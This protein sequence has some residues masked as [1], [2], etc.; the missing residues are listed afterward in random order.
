MSSFP[1]FDRLLPGFV[2]FKKRSVVSVVLV[3]ASA[4]LLT[5]S[6]SAQNTLV[7]PDFE[8]TGG[9]SSNY[10]LITTGP[11]TVNNYAITTN[12]SL[13]NP[14]WS[15]CTD[16]TS[17]S[18]KMMVVDGG[19]LPLN[20]V[21]EQVPGGGFSVVTGTVY[22]FS[23]WIA[24]INALNNTGSN[25][26][27]IKVLFDNVQLTPT[28][29]STTCPTTLCT[30]TKVEYT[31]TATNTYCQIWLYDTNTSTTANDFALDDFYFAPVPGPLSLTYSL[32]NPICPGASD[33]G[34]AV[35]GSGGTPP[36]TYSI[37]GGTYVTD[38]LFQGLGTSSNT[39]SIKDATGQVYT[40]T[41]TINL[42]G[43]ANPLVI[44]GNLSICSGS[45]T[46]TASGGNG[47]YSWTAS[48]TDATL[49]TP[50]AA[51]VTVSPIQ[52]TSYTV[53]SSAT[54]NANLIY[55]GNFSGGN[56]GFASDYTYASTNP[57]GAQKSYG[58][59]TNPNIFYSTFAACADHTSG[60]GNLLVADGSTVANSI[61]WRQK[62]PV[63]TNT[64]YTF[65]YWLESVTTSNPAQLETQING[66]PIT[67]TAATSTANALATTCTWSQVTY[68][69]NSGANTEAEITIYDRVLQSGGNDF[70]ID[71]IS[72]TSVY[73]CALSQTATVV[74]GSSTAPTA[75]VT[76][77]PNCT[78]ATG[79]ITVSAPTGA[80]LTYSIDGVTYTNT[81]G[82][83]S[84]IA[85]GT[86]NVTV[87][88]G[89]CVSPATVLTVNAV[90]PATAAPT[91]SVTTQPTCTIPTGTITITAPMGA[92]L[93]YSIDG[94]TYTNTTG[95]FTGL[96]A[97][98]YNVTVKNS[99]G[100]VSP[101]TVLVVNTVSSAPAAP[102]ASATTQPTCT[103]GTGTITITAPTGA[104]LTYSIDGISYTN[105]TGVFNGVAPGSYN[106]TVKNSGGCVSTATVVVINAAPATP[107]APTASVSAQPNCTTS[108]GTITVTAP[109]GS[110][111]TYSIDGTTYTNTTGV[112]TG[113][114]SGAYNVTVQNSNGCISP[115][116]VLTVNNAPTTPAAPTA[117]VTTQPT[118]TVATGTI[119][120][121]APTGA[122]LTYS[123]DGTNYTNTTGIFAG[124]APGSYNV[125]VKNSSGCISPATIVVVNGVSGVPSPP[126]VSVTAQPTCTVNTGTITVTSPLGGGYLYSIDG[127]TYTNTTGVFTNVLPGTYN[128]TIWK[129]GACISGP[130]VV[131][132]NAAPATPAAPTVSVTTQPTCTNPTGTITISAPVGAGLSYSIDG[133]T[134]TNTNGLFNSVI[135]GTYNVTVKNG[136]GCISPATP[137]TVNAAPGGP[138]TPT[139]T[140]T[141]QPT[142]TV[143]TGTITVSAPTGAGYTYSIDGLTYTNTTGIFNGVAPGSYNVT[144][145]NGSGCVSTATTLTVNNVPAGPAA[146]TASVTSSPTCSSPL[147]TITITAPL[148]A[149]LSYSIDGTSYTNTTGIFTG[150][151]SGSYNVTVK[152]GSGC[153]SGTTVVNVTAAVSLSLMLNATP[154]PVVFGNAVVL[155]VT[156]NQPFT[157]L[158]WTPGFSGS[159]AT[160]QTTTPDTTTTYMVIGTTAG[161]CID[162][163]SLTVVVNPVPPLNKDDVFVP[164]AFTPNGDG[165]NDILYVYSNYIKDMR[166][167]IFNQWGEQIF[168]TTTVGTGW[169]G[170][171][172]GKAQ[173]V[174]VYVYTLKAI[175]LDGTIVNKSGSVILIR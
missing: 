67:G 81:T 38:N 124:V 42:V 109:M 148:G 119:T 12:P 36:Y 37:N 71:D 51:S 138:A 156:G 25:L 129:I 23:Y 157:V 31:W 168:E 111:L 163:T 145:K 113:V 100:C 136:S 30:W 50:N 18:G 10:Q 80:G 39:V 74:V 49:T 66:A 4:L 76:A 155:T 3:A 171:S 104:G 83:F 130:T 5:V 97:G 172:K 26:P 128:V 103:T 57:S 106:V 41:S 150:L 78:T 158:S 77:Q 9:Y 102:T 169:D 28:L 34:I 6:A 65:S 55:N 151:A 69:W 118:C 139:A 43:A 173:P 125:T 79:T 141:T 101:A 116:T 164:N 92:G 45:T 133:T 153:V 167:T 61:L 54:S 44:S 46:L 33:G 161:G 89:T 122:G 112:F 70:A 121:S 98:T 56:N 85:P 144:V 114:A 165:I 174:T 135:A 11:S 108:T 14:A 175:L 93:T 137:V 62:I 159:T 147:G 32:V 140:V 21:W 64:N 170:T 58:V 60:T 105:T 132:V 52:N 142:C 1:S 15:N 40:G 7:N 87:K 2:F 162:T 72:F 82:I 73:N 8:T 160:T 110:G 149:G 13:I 94:A 143:P 47:T 35:Y 152:N 27:N 126:T 16:H 29:G 17:G 146:P 88:N 24:N 19:N 107:V 20:K 91:A 117:S 154:N 22:K 123:I 120:V 63:R 131:T 68:T 99:S 96:A 127:V 90:T 86:Y 134:Y 166:F 84:G 115:A 59:L 53:N 48:P 75:T 95:V